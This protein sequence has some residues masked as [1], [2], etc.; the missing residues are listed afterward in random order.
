[1]SKD[2]AAVAAEFESLFRD[3]YLRF[4][5]RDGRRLEISGAARAVLLHLSFSGPLTIG[6]AAQHFDRSQA[7]TSEILTQLESKGLLERRS[8]PQDRRR[9]LVWLT[10]AGQERLRGETSVLSADLLCAALDQLDFNEARAL[11]T[12]LESLVAAA[13]TTNPTRKKD[14]E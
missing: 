5:R 2:N 12:G 10:D 7:A 9:T 13:S 4:H 8:D 1:M 3:V 14:R 11:L 6:E